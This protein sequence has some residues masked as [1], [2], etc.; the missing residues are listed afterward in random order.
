MDKPFA[1]IDEQ[2]RLMERRGLTADENTPMILMRKGYYSTVNGYKLEKGAPIF[3]HEHI[4]FWVHE[5]IGKKDPLDVIALFVKRV[6][7]DRDNGNLHVE[8]IIGDDWD[9]TN[10]RQD[11][12][13]DESSRKSQMA[14]EVGF[15]PT[16]A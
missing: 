4:E 6:L 8:F 16:D 12:C 7:I 11:G 2:I 10:S 5:I 14:E 13:S 9:E 3:E 1:S 15:E